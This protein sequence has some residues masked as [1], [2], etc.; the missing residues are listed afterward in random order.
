M[1]LCRFVIVVFCISML[2]S[3]LNRG[4]IDGEVEMSFT[5]VATY[6][7][8]LPGD[9]MKFT[10]RQNDDSPLVTL[11]CQ[12]HFKDSVACGQRMVITYIPES[13]KAYTSG[14]A[15]LVGAAEISGG[16]SVSGDIADYPLWNR[17]SVYV[18]SMWRTGEYINLHSR[19]VYSKKPRVL[20]MLVDSATADSAVPTAYVVHC[21]DTVTDYHD[22]AYY[23]SWDIKEIWEKPG[24]KGLKVRVAN[25]NLPQ[26]EFQF[27]K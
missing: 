5:D 22:R 25:T 17:D 24:C 2:A 12:G 9:S 3:C 26:Q 6:E 1:T 13:G 4:T 18:Y 7:G 19:L 21:L 14:T 11:A 27:M 8:R 16:M 20:K 10:L 15:Y 23:V